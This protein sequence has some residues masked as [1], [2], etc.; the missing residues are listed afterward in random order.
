MNQKIKRAGVGVALVAVSAVTLT[1]CFGDDGD[2]SSRSREKAAAGSNYD[3]LVAN[4]PAHTGTY[5]PT[6]EN[7]TVWIVTWLKNQ[8]G[9]ASLMERVGQEGLNSGGGGRVKTK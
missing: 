1:G 7:T 9:R 4:Q 8:H 2:K 6:R 5:S 3:R